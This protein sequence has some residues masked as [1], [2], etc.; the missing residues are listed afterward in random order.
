MCAPCAP[1]W[2]LLG[3]FEPLCVRCHHRCC[4]ESRSFNFIVIDKRMDALPRCRA[5]ERMRTRDLHQWLVPRPAWLD[6]VRPLRVGV[7]AC[8][9]F[10]IDVTHMARRQDPILWP[11]SRLVRRVVCSQVRLCALWSCGARHGDGPP[12]RVRGV[13]TAA[14][15][16]ATARARRSRQC[17]LDG[18]D[19]AMEPHRELSCVM[20]ELAQRPVRQRGGGS[21]LILR[22]SLS[23]DS[24]AAWPPMNCCQNCWESVS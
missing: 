22:P 19:F 24:T 12:A 6:I 1:R 5:S 11:C 18:S 9:L 7:F 17:G 10:L 16:T 8:A 13:A 2:R 3:I 20:N 15:A 21:D 14:A 23:R 4:F